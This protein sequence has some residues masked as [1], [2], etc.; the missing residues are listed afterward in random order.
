MVLALFFGMLLGLF[1]TLLY[2]TRTYQGHDSHDKPWVYAIMITGKNT[3]RIKFARTAVKN[4]ENQDYLKK[5]LIIINHHPT[6]KVLN[7]N[8]NNSIVEIT[9]EKTD[10][11][12]GDLRNMALELVPMDATWTPWDDDDLRSHDF[13]RTMIKH[14][15]PKDYAVTFCNRFEIN[16][17]NGYVW[18]VSLKQK[19]TVHLVS[20][21]FDKRIKYLSKD[22]MEDVQLIDDIHLNGHT[23]HKIEDN[24][25]KMYIR[26]VHG[27]NTSLYVDPHKHDID[28]S[29]EW[30]PSHAQEKH[31][32][33]FL[34]L[35]Q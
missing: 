3:D 35:Y 2:A 34:A 1:L 30:K 7:D 11:T 9:V 24:D 18:G 4:F 23:I 12:L 8:K 6:L 32:K 26:T 10:T 15:S 33:E 14:L 25:P 21:A 28:K 22:S 5:K 27:D 29:F 20:R 13:L 16:M 19:G 17:K 31:V